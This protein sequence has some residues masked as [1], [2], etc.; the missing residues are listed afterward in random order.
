MT[1]ADCG[2]GTNFRYECLCGYDDGGISDEEIAL[3]DYVDAW[4]SKPRT[5]HGKEVRGL[6]S[7]VTA[8]RP[9]ERKGVKRELMRNAE[10]GVDACSRRKRALKA[11]ED[12]DWLID[13]WK[14]ETVNWKPHQFKSAF[15]HYCRQYEQDGE[16]PLYRSRT[17]ARWLNFFELDSTYE[18]AVLFGFQEQL[19]RETSFSVDANIAR[20]EFK[21]IMRVNLPKFEAR[22]DSAVKTANEN[23]FERAFVALQQKIAAQT[24]IDKIVKRTQDEL[25]WE[26]QKEASRRAKEERERIARQEQERARQEQI[27]VEKEQAA[28]TASRSTLYERAANFLNMIGEGLVAHIDRFF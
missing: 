23:R 8:T 20:L 25:E 15:E 17:V 26:Q 2:I 3:L 7:L 9:A 12:L 5:E 24:T 4:D 28:M 10:T 13:G 6:N 16:L 14:T 27:R 11:T 19:A 21:G 22:R 1:L 18:L